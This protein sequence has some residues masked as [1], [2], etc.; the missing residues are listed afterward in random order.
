MHAALPANVADIFSW[1]TLID[2]LPRGKKR[3]P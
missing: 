2:R 3:Q 1:L